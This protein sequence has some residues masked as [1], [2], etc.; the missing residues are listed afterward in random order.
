MPGIAA[1]RAM[2][3]RVRLRQLGDLRSEGGDP[4][5]QLVQVREASPAT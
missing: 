4:G 1:N 5:I 3:D 2:I